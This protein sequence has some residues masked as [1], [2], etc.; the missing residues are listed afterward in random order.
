MK[1]L[2][3]L[4]V[5]EVLPVWLP[6]QRSQCHVFRIGQLERQV[7]HQVALSR[8]RSRDMFH[9]IFVLWVENLLRLR[10]SLILLPKILSIST[11]M[12]RRCHLPVA[13]TKMPGVQLALLDRG[14]L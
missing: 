11:Q 14:L 3:L 4:S 5:H 10:R 12:P 7:V 9:L 6:V 2:T 8:R 13:L 1:R